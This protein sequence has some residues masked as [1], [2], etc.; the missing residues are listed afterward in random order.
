MK[1]RISPRINLE[2]R[3]PLETVIPLNT[4]FIL[5]VDPSSACNFQ[6]RFCPTGDHDLNRSTGK[7]IGLMSDDLFGKVIDDLSGFD[8]PLKVLRLY[9]DGE[10]L[11]NRKLPEMI[12]YAKQSGRAESIDT[13]TNAALLTP[14]VSERLIAAGLDRINVSI[15]GL[16]DEQYLRFAGVKVHF[17]DQVSNIRFFYENRNQCEV[18]VKIPDS[19]MRDDEKKLFFETFGDISDRIFIENFAPCWPEYDVET[20]TGVRITRGIYQNEIQHV[21]TCPYIFYSMSVNAD[22]LVSACFL[23][24]A[25]KLII[26]DARIQGIK[27]IWDG[28]E[29]FHFQQANLEGHRRGN[30]TCAACGQLTHCMPDNL[31]PFAGELLARCIKARDN[32]AHR[33]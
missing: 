4:P 20:R 26:G 22:G 5:F 10:P 33:D 25:R 27:E 31:D 12:A 30:P 32:H 9:K 2:G 3:T 18:C 15:C 14:E 21:E 16:N 24:W 29:L 7:F 11:L 28:R 13:T 19:G 17:A 23:D 1:A 8:S 6:C